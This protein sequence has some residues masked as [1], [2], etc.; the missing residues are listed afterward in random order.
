MEA[1]FF[2]EDP[3]FQFFGRPEG[4]PVI[5]FRKRMN[6]ANLLNQINLIGNSEGCGHQIE[7]T[8]WRKTNELELH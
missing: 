3:E 8:G 2:R 5:R 7:I 1:E 6:K 4:Y